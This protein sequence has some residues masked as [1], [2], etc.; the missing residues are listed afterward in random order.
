ME[1]TRTGSSCLRRLHLARTHTLGRVLAACVLIAAALSCGDDDYG[2]YDECRF[3]PQ[4]CRGG[5]GGLCSTNRDCFVGF[6]CQDKECGAGMCTVTCRA[7]LD[8]PADMAC[9]HGKCLFRCAS[10]LDC[11]YGQRCGHGHSVCE[12]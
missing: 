6:C 10:E 1:S 8:C 9:A 3:E 4:L 11:A 2:Y 12:W 7:D 5:W